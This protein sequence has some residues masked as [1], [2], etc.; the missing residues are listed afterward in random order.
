[1]AELPTGTVT[2]LFTDIEASTRLLAQLKERYG[3]L[4]ADQQRLLRAVFAENDGS[5]IDTQGDSFFVAFPRAKDAVAAAVAGQ[6]ALAKHEWP[7]DADVKVRMGLHTGEPSVGGERYIG[8][9]VHRAARIAAAAHGGQVLLS[10]VTRGLVE[11]ELPPDVEL[12]DMGEHRLKDLD[13]P[14]RLSQ[15]VIAGLPAAFPQPRTAGPVP[16]DLSGREQALGEAA[17]EA[18]SG[19]RGR[20]FWLVA[21]TAALAAGA[22]LAAA[23]VVFTGGSGSGAAARGGN[24]LAVINPTGREVD[25]Y[26]PVGG[27]PSD[28]TTG[29]GAVWVLDANDLTI[30]KIDPKTRKIVRTFGSGQT[31]TDLAVG[32]NAIWVGNGV[33]APGSEQVGQL[34]AASVS[35]ISPS[36]NTI[37]TKLPGRQGTLRAISHAGHNTFKIPGITQLVAGPQGVW[38]IDPDQTVSKLDPRSGKIVFV[39]R[40]VN[41]NA[42]AIGK[43]GVWIIENNGATLARIDPRSGK[44][45]SKITPSAS[46]FVGIAVG[47]GSVW[48]TDPFDGTVWRVMP[49][50]PRDVTQT[51]PVGTGAT[52]ISVGDGQVWVS[53]FL[54]GTVSRVDPRTNAV[55]QK[56]PVKGTPKA[57]AAG[58][59]ATW[60]TVNQSSV[61]G[62]ALSYQGTGKPDFVIASD[63]PLHGPTGMVTAQM[64][65]AVK[66]VLER[67]G[68]RAGRFSVGYRSCDDSTAQGGAF[69][70]Y[71]CAANAHAYADDQSVIGV[72][73]TYNSGCAENEVSIMDRAK[74]GPVAMISPAT[75]DPALTHQTPDVPRSFLKQLYPTGT[76]NFTR[77]VSP[78]DYQGAAIAVLA[79]QLGL[80]R[81]FILGTAAPDSAA[82]RAP[83]VA[84]LTIAAKRLGL[85]IVG[86]ASWN[87]NGVSYRSLALRVAQSKAQGVAIVDVDANGEALIRDLRSRGGGGLK[88]FL[89]D[90]WLPLAPIIQKTGPAANG[91]YVPFYSLA[92]S[93]LS[94]AGKQFVRQLHT[95]LRAPIQ[96]FGA[97]PA[98][99]AAEALL[100][101][102]ARSNGTR[103][104]VNEALRSTHVH[105][106]ILGSFSFDA[107]GDIVPAKF[108]IFRIVGGKRRNPTNVSDFEGAVIDRAVSVPAGLLLP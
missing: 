59:G 57:L 11:E 105:N 81:I 48:A 64:V 32:A 1:M 6:R 61:A 103:A 4:L 34:Y 106:G 49:G 30:S 82:L 98:G 96:S 52:D 79:R 87:P 25:R 47:A 53:N 16:L 33:S 93:L 35:R 104:S 8:L 62:C 7:D 72:I 17:F 23:V 97:A 76:R 26:L 65:A 60:L 80:R 102:I 44:I 50:P 42:I 5:E 94:T 9:G 58:E 67:R 78:D 101:A 70:F 40:N 15:L 68:Y 36:A 86:K 28:V 99:Q 89:N 24:A 91:L 46:G 14:E 83:L 27:A 19:G 85:Q 45:V 71:K 84:S 90:F 55:A 75:T 31:P 39:V 21:A 92:D 10:S 73:G 95:Q 18:V 54:D 77:V 69:D 88:I 43:E 22:G 20:R 74:P 41:A 66:L 13:R 38:A 63:L 3:D 108:T 37:I 29:D 56:I 107:N 51:I 100:D 12:R 2:F